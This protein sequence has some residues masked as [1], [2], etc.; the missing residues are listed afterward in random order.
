MVTASVLTAPAF[1]RKVGKDSTV[2]Q[3]TKT[4]F[5][6]YPIVLVM[7][8]L[9]WTP[10]RASVIPSGVETIVQNNFATSIVA[11]MEPVSVKN[12]TAK[13]DGVAIC[14]TRNSVTHDAMN[15]VS[16]RTALVFVLPVGMVNTVQ[17]RAVPER[18]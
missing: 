16:V 3:W 8:L 9:S 1:V 10:N 17:L 12:V 5:N 13:M 11:A 4:L 15:M 14:A 6:A 18:K 2:V 7:V